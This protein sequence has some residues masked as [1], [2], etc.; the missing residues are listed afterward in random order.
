MYIPAGCF[1]PGGEKTG[2]WLG[3]QIPGYKTASYR[4]ETDVATQRDTS[5]PPS[6]LHAVFVVARFEIGHTPRKNRPA[7]RPQP[8]ASSHIVQ[9]AIAAKRAH[10]PL[11]LQSRPII[12]S[13]RQ[14]DCKSFLKKISWK[15]KNFSPPFCSKQRG[16][17][18][19]IYIVFSEEIRY[20]M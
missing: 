17:S 2:N 10:F 16:T 19:Y 12:I 7:K 4:T 1:L 15:C 14:V 18:T 3:F 11:Y 13:Y 6:V 20:Q 8:P 9:S 5:V